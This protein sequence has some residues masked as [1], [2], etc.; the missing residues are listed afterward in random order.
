MTSFGVEIWFLTKDYEHADFV[1]RELPP[2]YSKNENFCLRKRIKLINEIEIDRKDLC[3]RNLIIEIADS[4]MEKNGLKILK[5]KL[6]HC[7]QK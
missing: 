5:K 2:S 1:S 7:N 6:G 3:I 4:Q